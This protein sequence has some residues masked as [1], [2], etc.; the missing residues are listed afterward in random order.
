MHY[1]GTYKQ[2]VCA[3]T[4]ACVSPAFEQGVARDLDLF[5]RTLKLTAMEK[6]ARCQSHFFGRIHQAP[7]RKIYN[8]VN[9]SK[10]MAKGQTYRFE[11]RPIC[12]G[13]RTETSGEKEQQ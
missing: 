13:V 2:C 4:C 8:T 6:Y 5:A 7:I 12:L 10:V 3:C 9:I 1:G 11:F